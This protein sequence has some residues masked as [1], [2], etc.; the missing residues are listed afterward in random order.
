MSVYREIKS[1]EYEEKKWYR[2][3]ISIKT[4]PKK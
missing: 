4:S 3:T 1:S 2:V